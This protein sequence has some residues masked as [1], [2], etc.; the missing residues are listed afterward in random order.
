MNTLYFKKLSQQS[1]FHSPLSK[2]PSKIELPFS[3]N[4]KD[5]VKR[6]LANVIKVHHPDQKA[7]L[8]VSLT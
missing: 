3:S 7:Y 8:D 1:I 5:E 4:V 2:T 6:S